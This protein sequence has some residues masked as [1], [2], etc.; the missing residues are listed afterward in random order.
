MIGAIAGAMKIGNKKV[1]KNRKD[2][3]L[4]RREKPGSKLKDNPRNRKS[5]GGQ[6]SS[7]KG[8]R[9]KG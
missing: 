7:K 2:E 3:K 4:V 9:A 6:C 1:K 5:G 8:T